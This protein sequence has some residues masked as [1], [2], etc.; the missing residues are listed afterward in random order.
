VAPEKATT[1]DAD[2][3]TVFLD[4]AAEPWHT[5]DAYVAENGFL[6]VPSA[7]GVKFGR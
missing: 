2:P 7:T 3:S 5:T 6:M 1:S 4:L